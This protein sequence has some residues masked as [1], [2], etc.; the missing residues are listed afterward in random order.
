MDLNHE[1]FRKGSYLIKDES[2][3]KEE[4]DDVMVVL[5][6]DRTVHIPVNSFFIGSRLDI[7]EKSKSCR[8]SFHGRVVQMMKVE[9]GE[10]LNLEFYKEKSREG[11]I[12]RFANSMAV[13]VRRMFKKGTDISVFL[14]QDVSLG[15]LKGTIDSAFGK[16]GKI[17]VVLF[18]PVADEL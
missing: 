12:D 4:D 13:I 9:E 7:G 11:V 8:L 16:S 3:H 1:Q 5:Y 14:G 6:L 18:E 2:K 10:T 17:K 15:D